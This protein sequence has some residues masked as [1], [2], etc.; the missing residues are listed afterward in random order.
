[1]YE[2]KNILVTGGTGSWGAAVVR[3]LLDRKPN[4][5][6]VFSRNESVQMFMQKELQDHHLQFYRGDIRDKEALLQ[7]CS[8]MDYVFHL[9]AMKHVSVCE[10]L[11]MEAHQTNVIGTQNVIEAAVTNRVKKVIHVSTVKAANP[12]SIYGMTKAISEKLMICANLQQTDTRFIC[13]RGGN[14]LGASE[15]AL[16]L[17]QRQ[18]SNNQ[19]IGITDLRMT[20]FFLTLQEASKLLIKSAI[21]GQ[22]GE[23]FILNMAS[24]KMADLAEVLREKAGRS[25]PLVETEIRPGEK[26]N[27]ILL[28]DSELDRAVVFS[29][30]LFVILPTVDTR[31]LQEFYSDNAPLGQGNYCSDNPII[32]LTKKEI[33]Q[34]LVEA[35]L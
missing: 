32:L 6:V 8:G 9:A 11:P 3:K 12:N 14:L 35:G 24:C 10:E 2:N 19:P 31:G 7:A 17:F 20:R 1:M 33:S 26:L 22:G 16:H 29:P 18:I 21:V 13:V 4:K 27:D 25:V 28:T 15:S 23:T 34:L 5:V 30:E